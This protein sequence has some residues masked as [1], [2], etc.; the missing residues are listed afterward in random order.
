MSHEDLGIVE[1]RRYAVKPGARDTLIELFDREFVETQEAVGM[2]VLGQFRDLDDPDSFVWLRGFP[3]MLTRKRAL[4]AFYGGPVWN[5]HGPAANAT[6]LD[7]SNVLLLRPLSR[8]ELDTA[9]RSGPGATRAQSGLLAVT[10]YPLAG[11]AAV[12]FGGFFDGEVESA[13]R[14]AGISVLATFVTEHSENT[15]PQLPLREDVNVF[16]WMAMYADELDHA[17]R[18]TAL[19]GSPAWRDQIAP[20][21]A[22]HVTG[23]SEVLRLMPTARS[24]L[25]G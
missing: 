5:E 6:M 8:L 9:D 20:A 22:S 21:L 2:Q 7:V 23:V 16:A 18:R 14:N 1:L 10:I 11:G 4:E 17:R 13:L 19:E 25:H 3:D 15:F 24:L 12:D